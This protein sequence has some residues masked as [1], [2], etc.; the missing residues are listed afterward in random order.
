MAQVA[1]SLAERFGE[2]A[3]LYDMFKGHKADFARTDLDVYLPNLY[4]T[5]SD[6]IVL[7]LCEDYAKK[8]WCKLEW[9]F[10]RQLIAT[11]DEGRIMFLSFDDIGAVPELEFLTAMVTFQ[12]LNIRRMKSRNSF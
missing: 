10:I 12:L 3:V 2:A 1:A 6:L 11:A 9:R 8:R 5:E 4:R 7:F